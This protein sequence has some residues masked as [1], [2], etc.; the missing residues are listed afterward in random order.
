MTNIHKVT[1]SAGCSAGARRFGYS[2][3]TQSR[4]QRAY[5]MGGE[6]P[7]NGEWSCVG[8]AQDAVE[9]Q[10]RGFSSRQRNPLE[11]I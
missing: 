2:N 3:K 8:Y 7:A 9:P 10:R 11:D 4:S 6:T 5:F 1:T